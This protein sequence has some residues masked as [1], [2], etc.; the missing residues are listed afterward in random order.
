MKHFKLALLILLLAPGFVA[1]QKKAKKPI[2]PAVFNS[3]RFVYVQAV[4]GQEF[5][6]N[7]YPEDRMAI[8]DVRDALQV[9]GRYTLTVERDKADL[10]FVVR[11]GRLASADVDG[12]IG[13]GQNPQVGGQRVQFPGN[14][15]QQG[16]GAGGPASAGVGVGAEAGPPDDLLQVCQLTPNGKLSAPLWIHS[17]ANGLDAPRLLLFKQFKDAVEKAYPNPPPKP[18]TKP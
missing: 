15:R 4:D 13:T 16:P 7:L 2:V 1:A 18:P 9:W 14:Q 17:F 12:G 6:R 3:A 11:K 5:D 10:V 8:A